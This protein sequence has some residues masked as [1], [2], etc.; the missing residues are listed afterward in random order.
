MPTYLFLSFKPL[1]DEVKSSVELIL[2]HCHNGA[3][4]ITL[5]DGI[6]SLQGCTK[7]AIFGLHYTWVCIC[8]PTDRGKVDHTLLKCA[9]DWEISCCDEGLNVPLRESSYP[10][11][12]FYVTFI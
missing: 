11:F 10:M 9:G 7:R 5:E 6:N 1:T 4:I 8:E 12:K 3:A 2:M